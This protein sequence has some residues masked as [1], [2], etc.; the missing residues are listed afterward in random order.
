M[1]ACS[2]GKPD[3]TILYAGTFPSAD[4]SVPEMA[5]AFEAAL[6]EDYNGDGK[7]D[8][9]LAMLTVY[10]EE[11]IKALEKDKSENAP[12]IDRNRNATEYQKFQNL[13]VSGE[14]YVCLLDPWLFD[15]VNK[16]GMFMPLSEVL[17]Y[18]LVDAV[19]EYAVK[20]SDTEFGRYYEA[21]G[22]LPEDTYLCIRAPGAVQEMIGKGKNSK[23]Y[24]RAVATVK[25]IIEFEAPEENK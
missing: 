3:I 14:Y 17:G 4:S 18:E 7:K 9:S 13:I 22:L 20:L 2:N 16:D 10:S 1:Q 6:P 15:T 8:V 19:N 12:Q 23:S 5:K 24:E 21:L 11:Q 25:A